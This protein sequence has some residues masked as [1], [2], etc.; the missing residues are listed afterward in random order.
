MKQ[1]EIVALKEGRLDTSAA[2]FDTAELMDDA[3]KD[4]SG[5]HVIEQPTENIEDIS[6]TIS[7]IKTPKK[8]SDMRSSK[9]SLISKSTKKKTQKLIQSEAKQQYGAKNTISSK[10]ET[11]YMAIS[12]S[13]ERFNDSHAK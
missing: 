1:S 12:L 7:H 11:K 3:Q 4:V 10:K 13:N 2:Q 5:E 6:M 9:P 8:V